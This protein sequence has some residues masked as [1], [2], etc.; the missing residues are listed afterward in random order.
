M[1]VLLLALGSAVLFGAMTVALR[2]ALV[3]TREPV[4]GALV[5]S[6][7]AFAVC[8][9]AV[10]PSASGDGDVELHSLW[11][12]AL[13]GLLAPGESQLLFLF[14]VRD[15][16]PSRTSVVLGT[17]PLVSVA[18]ALVALGEPFR[19]PLAAGALLIVFG[20]IALVRERVR[21]ETFKALGVGLAFAGATLFAVRDNLVR[22]LAGETTAPPL[23]A[24]SAAVL[25]GSALI[26]LFVLVTGRRDLRTRVP[27]AVRAFAPAGVLF[28]VSYALL[29]EA[30]YRGRVSVVAPLVATESLWAVVL[31]ALFL[32]R[33]ELI[34]RHLVTG[35][36]L[37]VAGGVLIGTFR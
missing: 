32:R 1:T 3:R 30:Y 4:L 36:T 13:T 35:A 6:L 2:F 16:G 19:L 21:P 24:A 12:F 17:A 7:V 29:F 18:V 9:I 28:G 31:S 34:G 27:T 14:A 10:S 37:I 5:T 11:P 26:A 15:A 8:A 22:W 23:L 25:A 20:A 33:T